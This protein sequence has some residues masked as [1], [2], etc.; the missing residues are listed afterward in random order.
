MNYSKSFTTGLQYRWVGAVGWLSIPITPITP[1]TKLRSV[2]PFAEQLSTVRVALLNHRRSLLPVVIRRTLP[3]EYRNK[4]CQTDVESGT[5][6][7]KHTPASETPK[8]SG[9]LPP[10]SSWPT[11]YHPRVGWLSKSRLMDAVYE[12]CEAVSLIP[13]I[14]DEVPDWIEEVLSSQRDLLMTIIRTVNSCPGHVWGRTFDRATLPVVLC[15]SLFPMMREYDST[16][17]V[18]ARHVGVEFQGFCRAEVFSGRLWE[19]VMGTKC[20][21]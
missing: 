15:S 9:H 13:T 6:S 7:Q 19:E 20:R 10:N 16:Q 5:I 3:V 14:M 2:E 4:A 17:S 11:S 8:T 21:R 1:I 12:E 18:L